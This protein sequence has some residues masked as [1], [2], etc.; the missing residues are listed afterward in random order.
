M[1][2]DPTRG[3]L[4]PTSYALLGLLAVQ[5]WTTYELARQMERTLARFWPRA[6]SKVYEE[7]KKL[8]RLGLAVDERSATGRRPR[9]VYRIT[10]EGRR[11]LSAWLAEPGAPPVLEHEQL[12]KIFFAEAGTTADVRLQLAEARRWAAARREVDV[13]VGRAQLTGTAPFPAR[14]AQN[15]VVGRLLSDFAV[16]VDEWAQWA[17]GVVA[18]WPDDPAQAEADLTTVRRLVERHERLVPKS[19]TAVSSH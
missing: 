19:E 7:P 3:A 6:R 12:L 11:A 9:T 4:T 17:E 2:S 18:E 5:P 14:L 8:V 13:E 16:L 1:T 10:P 15:I